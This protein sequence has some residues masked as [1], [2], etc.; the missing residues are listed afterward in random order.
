M[1][2]PDRNENPHPVTKGAFETVWRKL[3]KDREFVP[4]E[5]GGYHFACACIALLPEV[6]YSLN[7]ETIW[8]SNNRHDF[9]KLVEKTQ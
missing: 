4:V 7:P 5:D 2:R 8:L 9:G 1:T 6:E 3:L